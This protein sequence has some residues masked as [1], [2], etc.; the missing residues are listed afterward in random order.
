MDYLA[1]QVRVEVTEFAKYSLTG[2]TV[3]YHRSQ[4]RDELGF[5]L[6]PRPTSNGGR[7]G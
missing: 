7:G 3:E 4:I 6:G 5:R 2:R 1:S